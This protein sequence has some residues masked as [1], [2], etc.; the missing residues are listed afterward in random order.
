VG[1]AACRRRR[2][3][4]HRPGHSRHTGPMCRQAGRAA[5]VR[6]GSPCGGHGS[7]QHAIGSQRDAVTGPRGLKHVGHEAR[8][9]GTGLRDLVMDIP[10][11]ADALLRGC[12]HSCKIKNETHRETYTYIHTERW[13]PLDR[14]KI[15]GSGQHW[16]P[17][18]L[19]DQ[20]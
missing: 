19:E 17:A 9:K 18:C 7:R 12:C 15:Q 2:W 13:I 6:A 5:E 20:S 4:R 3:P 16:L 1:G 14:Q 10:A 8:D 11:T